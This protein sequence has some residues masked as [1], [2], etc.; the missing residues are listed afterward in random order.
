MRRTINS[1]ATMLAMGVA[2]SVASS[3]KSA[4]ADV[5]RW[6]MNGN[7]CHFINFA[8]SSPIYQYSGGADHAGKTFWDDAGGSGSGVFFTCPVP[9]GRDL[10]ELVTTNGR[11]LKSVNVRLQQVSVSLNEYTTAELITSSYTGTMVCTCDV[12]VRFG[13]P[14]NF[15]LFLSYAP[16]ANFSTCGTDWGVGVDFDMTDTGGGADPKGLKIRLLSAYSD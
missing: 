7:D 14:G 15:P 8:G 9:T 5:L 3:A 13:G 12:K 11:R 1:T 16:C 6:R 2:L 4:G 10:V